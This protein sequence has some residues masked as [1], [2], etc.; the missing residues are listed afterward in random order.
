[1]TTLKTPLEMF[2][3]WEKH[4]PQDIFLR[5]S[6]GNGEWEEMT[7]TQVA[8]RVRRITAFIAAKQLPEASNIALW[9]SNCADWVIVDLAIML[10][11]HVSIPLYPGQAVDAVRHILDE[12]DCSLIFIGH[13]G[14]ENKIDDALPDRVERIGMHNCQ[15]PYHKALAQVVQ[16][17]PVFKESPVP[18]PDQLMTIAYSSGTG[19]NPK[20]VMHSHGTPAKVSPVIARVFRLTPQD[21]T[22]PERGR[23]FSFLPLA[24]MAERGLVW[25]TGLYSNASISFSAGLDS[26]TQEIQEVQPTFFFAVPRLWHKFK[27][28]VESKLGVID[29]ERLG[30]PQKQMIRQQLGLAHADFILSSSAPIPT[31]VHK[32]FLSLGIKLRECYGMTETFATGVIWHKDDNPIAGSVGTAHEGVEARIDDDGEIFLR[33]LGNM[34]GYYKNPELT[35]QVLNDGWFKTGDLGEIDAEGNIRIT[36]RVG[37][38]FKTSKGKFVNPERVEEQLQKIG[39]FEQLVVVGDGLELPIAVATLSESARQEDYDALSSRIAAKLDAINDRLPSEEVV[40]KVIIASEDWTI[41]NGFLT[42][43]SKLKRKKSGHPLQTGA[44]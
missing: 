33:S 10:S 38:I 27:E 23:L 1:M 29:P 15:V 31:L 34:L 17:Y 7:W 39:D 28:A 12:T 25:M 35:R 24:H 37:S 36:G 3:H 4:H 5:Q 8:D 14:Q 18:A 43:T 44:V 13:C 11:G 30:E 19:G 32:W 42:P 20:G 21:M 40:S 16:E 2:Y 6:L 9:S 22:T 26:F 41:D